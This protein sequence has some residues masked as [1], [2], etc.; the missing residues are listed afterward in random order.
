MVMSKDELKK[1][2]HKHSTDPS[3]PP[4]VPSF[5]VCPY[6]DSAPGQPTDYSL[7]IYPP[8]T[9]PYDVNIAFFTLNDYGNTI[10]DTFLTHLR[11]RPAI[12][13]LIAQMQK[14]N[15]RIINSMIDTPNINWGNANIEN[16]VRNTEGEFA[17]DGT[18]FTNNL[19][20]NYPAVG[21]MWD[22]E[23]P[24]PDAFAEVMKACFLRGITRDPDNYVFI[25][26]TY[27]DRSIDE[28][29]NMVFDASKS[30][31]DAELIKLG[32]LRFTDLFLKR[33]PGLS[34]IETM[35]YSGDAASRFAE[36]DNY[37][38]K[39]LAQGDASQLNAMR[40]YLSIGVAPELT[41]PAD[42]QAIG[43]ACDPS[44]EEGYGRF[45]VWAGNCP[46]GVTLF[47]NMITARTLPITPLLPKDST[48]FE[49]TRKKLPSPSDMRSGN[50]A[51]LFS[52][53]PE[54]IKNE[55]DSASEPGWLSRITCG[56]FDSCC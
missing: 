50:R 46:D 5:Y 37:A 6:S 48:A 41:A 55:E 26:T 21:R 27:A 30:P 14:N 19:M 8:D 53:Q 52:K 47:N 43:S 32:F 45:M 13:A 38:V 18:F 49:T 31:V 9:I 10:D 16:F 56:L 34:W 15:R 2:A 1:R 42:A 7:T 20:Q 44:K 3:A 28:L 22:A 40:K 29:L 33:G 17:E 54:K 35:S 12:Q 23:T 25:Y 36:A 11:D 39:Y 24:A 4:L 51:R